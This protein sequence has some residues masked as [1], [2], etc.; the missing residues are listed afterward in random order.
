MRRSACSTAN[1]SANICR[2]SPAV[3]QV[4]I[5]AG[6]FSGTT[7]MRRRRSSRAGL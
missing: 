3:I 6:C 7:P 1:S 4:H 5:P 2:Y